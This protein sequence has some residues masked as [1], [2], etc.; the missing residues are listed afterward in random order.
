M[1][2][3]QG[4][5]DFLGVHRRLLICGNTLISKVFMMV[6]LSQEDRQLEK[7]VLS[8]LSVEEAYKHIE[9]LD[10]NVGQRLAGTPQERK[11]ARYFKQVL[12]SYGIPAKIFK[13][14]AYISIPKTSELKLLKPERK[15]IEC[16]CYSQIAS[17]SPGG[18]EGEL[19]YVGQGGR[20][21][22]KGLDVKGKITLAEL[23]YSPPRPEKVRL[24]ES[25]GSIGQIQIN[26]SPKEFRVLP[27]GTVKR[28]WGNPTPETIHEMPNIPAIG[29][30]RADGEYLKE[31]C[32]KGIVRVW[33]RA[34]AWRGWGKVVQPVAEVRGTAEPEYF[35]LANGHYDAWGPAATCN[36]TGNTLLIELARVFS[37]YK[38]KLRRS[39][40]FA[41]WTAHETGIMDGSTWYLDNF[42]RDLD[43]HAIAYMN[44]DSPGMKD[45]L[46]YGPVSSEETAR[47]HLETVKDVLGDDEAKI[48][49]SL[50]ERPPKTGDQ[51]FFGIGVPS[52]SGATVPPPGK[53]VLGWWYHSAE[54]TPDKV[55]LDA[56]AKAMRMYAA[57]IFRLCNSPILPYDFTAVAEKMIRTLSELNEKGRGSVD[58]SPLVREAKRLR[59]RTEALQKSI[60]GLER[61]LSKHKETKELRDASNKV[62][63]CLMRLSR[64][65]MPVNYTF[66]GKYEQDT[67]GRTGLGRPIPMLQPVIELS[68][69]SP[70]S[71]EYKLLKT[72]LV[73]DRNKVWDAIIQ[74]IELLDQTLPQL[75]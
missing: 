13:F 36:A 16:S 15:T 44:C 22:Y 33:M 55:D 61:R 71:D 21:D 19:I 3:E 74:A 63:R 56:F 67:Y 17:T 11:T 26:W 59:V 43:E 6:G 10:K 37:K 45:T 51:S 75:H 30:T 7:R 52:I 28:V 25:F 64:I 46:H 48:A 2:S 12:K 27:L 57:L 68:T 66:V 8:E 50:L 32:S 38:K 31:L 53:P 20:D 34:E 24:A 54:D 9:W 14:D 47:F 60:D 40:R 73:R 18:I 5:K 72:R 42:W 41:W 29:V 62:N 58:L 23:S 65:L 39:V 35:V 4:R 1:I 69:M 49:A 70:E